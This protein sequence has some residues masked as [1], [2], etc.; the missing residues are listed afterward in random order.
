MEKMIYLVPIAGLIAL[1]Y[2]YF[3]AKWVANREV[4]TDRMRRIAGYI[5]EGAMAFLQAEYKV[6]FMFALVVA[7]FV[8]N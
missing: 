4:G 6:L 7:I 1:L 8:V 3:S 2:T 5:T